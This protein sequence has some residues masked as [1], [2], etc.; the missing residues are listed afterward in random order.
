MANTQID[1]FGEL[2]P[3]SGGDGPK[4]EADFADFEIGVFVSAEA[5]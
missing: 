4:S 2:T 3:P 1:A 5:H